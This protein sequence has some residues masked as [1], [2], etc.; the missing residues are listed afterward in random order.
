MPS[1]ET[2]SDLAP[3]RLLAQRLDEL[4]NGYPAAP[5]GSE[6]R[7]LAY[8]YTPEEAELAA[9]LLPGLETPHEIARRTERDLRDLVG[10][11][12]GMS[13]KGL[14]ETGKTKD[15]RLG[16]GLMPFVVGIYEA[17]AGRIDA[18]FAQ[19]FEDYYQASFKEALSM[20]PQVHRVIPVNE[21]VR[22]DME[23][24]PYESAA[25][26]V[27]NSQA[28]GVVSCI[29]RDQKALIGDP[30]EHPRDV[31]MIVSESPG[32]FEGSSRVQAQTMEESLATLQRA[33]NAGLV[34]SVSNNQQGLW[35]ICNCC[36]CSCGILRGMA[37]LGMANVVA[38]SSFVCEVDIDACT[39]CEAC[40]DACQFDA[41]KV[42]D[43]AVVDL[44]R[45]VGCG[46]C[47]LEC[48]TDAMTLVRRAGED[49]PPETYADW[50]AARIAARQ[51]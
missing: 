13:R 32:A 45:C 4:P 26:I 49:E 46:L 12:K 41:I 16:F 17:Q 48:P 5:D 18:E 22:N 47:A 28:W 35:Y 34:H 24:R 50:D 3:Y 40:V 23:V 6:L 19:L 37:E 25:G 29:C 11:L 39:A 31:C 14:I 38:R 15:G 30:C 33:S 10:L 44:I 42:D 20:Q 9:A 21:T 51:G 27:E 36:T 8:L 43:Y 7:L 2:I 1:N